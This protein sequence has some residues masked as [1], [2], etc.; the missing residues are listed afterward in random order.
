MDIGMIVIQ[1][2][3]GTA[4]VV[5]C[6]EE[7]TG[8]RLVPAANAAEL[9]DQATRVVAGCFH[10]TLDQDGVY[11][12]TDELQAAAVFPPLPL[13]ADAITMREAG[14]LL[15]PNAS[16]QERWARLSTL[17]NATTLRIYRL[18]IAHEIKQYV[19]R[20]AAEQFVASRTGG[21]NDVP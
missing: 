10:A 11:L 21:A 3:D 15:A 16:P 12:C 14:L 8:T 2:K 7:S 4:L 17:R 18:G 9:A 19:S 1:V 5:R 20:S 13:P 6:E